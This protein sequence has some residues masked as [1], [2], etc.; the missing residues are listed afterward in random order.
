LFYLLRLEKPPAFHLRER[1]TAFH[2]RDVRQQSRLFA[3]W[4]N[5]RRVSFWQTERPHTSSA[6]T[7]MPPMTLP[8][9]W[10]ANPYRIIQPMITANT[11]V[12]TITILPIRFIFSAKGKFHL[13]PDQTKETKLTNIA[14]VT[15][16]GAPPRTGLWLC[17]A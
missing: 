10:N 8:P 12:A 15:G 17:D 13:T 16:I 9:I 4:N 2:R 11:P 14:E 7:M 6:M 1:R 3:R 5:V